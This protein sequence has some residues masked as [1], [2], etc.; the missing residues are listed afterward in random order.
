MMHTKGLWSTMMVW[1]LMGLVGGGLQGQPASAAADEPQLNAAEKEFAALLADYVAKFKQLWMRQTQAWWDASLTGTDADFQ[2]RK[3]AETALVELHSDRTVLAKLQALRSGGQVKEPQLRR[4]LELLYLSFLPA[5]ADPEL[6]K[7]IVVLEADVEQIFNTHRSL[8]DGV[9]KTENDVRKTLADTA[10]S[11]VAEKV[12]KGY[13]AVGVKVEG[14]LKELVR[15]RNQLAREMGFSDYFAMSLALQEIDQTQL[16]RL[17]DELDELTRQPFA[18]MKAELDRKMA[19]RFGISVADLRPWHYSDLFFQEDPDAKEVGLDEI[20]K[21]RDILA[22]AKTY[23]AGVGLPAE[24][25]LARSD[26]YEK[27]GKSPHAFCHDMDRAGDIRVLANLQPNTNWMDTLLHEL[28]HGVYDK[29]ISNGLPFVLHEAAHGITTE[30]IALMFGAM[31]FNEEWLRDVAKVP[32]DQAARMAAA[33]QETLR[34]QKVIFS[35]WAQVMVRFEQGMYHDPDQDL[36]RLWWDLKKRYQLLNPPDDPSRPDY[37]AKMH[38]VAAPVYYQSYMMG[39]LFASQVQ[40]HIARTILK[41]DKPTR[42]AF[43]GRP[44]V[45]E[46][47]RTKVFGPGKLLMWDE[48]TRTATGEPLS[49]KYFAQMYVN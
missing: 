7:K 4:Q 31:T 15:L 38:I 45:G 23:Y 24:D 28:G 9:P 44:E 42:T 8:V 35:R 1:G 21:Q 37:G 48:L 30:G 29:Y 32:E 49:A 22:L 25:V 12:W 14:K 47:L 17:F 3:D 41:V 40:H 6:R 11:A 18:E 5:Q 13:M 16:L 26:L 27:D 46:Y 34:H 2:R 10:D 33:A 19:A 36:G 20:F 43:V 39:D